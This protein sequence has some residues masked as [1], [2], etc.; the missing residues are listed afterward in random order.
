LVDPPR[1]GGEHED[2]DRAAPSMLEARNRSHTIWDTP[3]TMP[4]TW[5]SPSMK[6]ATVTTSPPWRR[7]NLCA[8]SKGVGVRKM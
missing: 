2:A 5:R 6:R 3:A 1:E 8:V 7:K 4:L